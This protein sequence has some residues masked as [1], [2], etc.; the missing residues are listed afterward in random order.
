MKTQSLQADMAMTNRNTDLSKQL[1]KHVHLLTPDPVEQ[2]AGLLT[3]ATTII[4]VTFGTAQAADILA[5]MI[6]PSVQTWQLGRQSG[7]SIQ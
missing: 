3:A 7:E 2:I 6:T 4:E 5:V 1:L